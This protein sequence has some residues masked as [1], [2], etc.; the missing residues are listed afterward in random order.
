M[1]EPNSSG[2][3][4]ERA[5]VAVLAFALTG[6]GAFVVLWGAAWFFLSMGR[7]TC[8]SGCY[9]PVVPDQLTTIIIR[10]A[11]VV[12]VVAGIAGAR[13]VHTPRP[14]GDATKPHES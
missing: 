9:G 14:P 1:S 2:G 6:G 7:G 3:W 10:I 12:G 11:L 13:P 8:S 4:R 5:F